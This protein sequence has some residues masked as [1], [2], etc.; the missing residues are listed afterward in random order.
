MYDVTAP[1]SALQSATGA[2]R[3]MGLRG[4]PPLS[5]SHCRWDKTSERTFHSANFAIM[6]DV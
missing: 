4:L 2:Q 6:E 3:A 5:G 1:F